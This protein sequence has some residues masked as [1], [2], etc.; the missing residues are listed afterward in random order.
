MIKLFQHIYHII[1]KYYSAMYDTIIDDSAAKMHPTELSYTTT[2]K[3]SV[4]KREYCMHVVG[5]IMTDCYN[6]VC[7]YSMF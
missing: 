1:I 6:I 4:V 5:N 7:P 2:V 3:L